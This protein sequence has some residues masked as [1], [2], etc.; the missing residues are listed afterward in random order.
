ML[1]EF[2][3]DSFAAQMVMKIVS[4]LQITVK[5]LH[6]RFEDELNGSSG[7]FAFGV[8]LEQMYVLESVLGSQTLFFPCTHLFH[9]HVQSTD[10][11]WQQ[12]F[13]TA[14]KANAKTVYKVKIEN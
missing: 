13:I 8:T 3:D 9:R 11:F 7:P 1:L 10:E 2:S 12:T 5:R 4:N 14:E 6:V